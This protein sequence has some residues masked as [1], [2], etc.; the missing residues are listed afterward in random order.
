MYKVYEAPTEQQVRNRLQRKHRVPE[1]VWN[2]PHIKGI[3]V[4]CTKQQCEVEFEEK[5]DYLREQVNDL[6]ENAPPETAPVARL[7][8]RRSTGWRTPKEPAVARRSRAVSALVAMDA[9]RRDDV[10]A[11]RRDVLGD[12]LL[13]DDEVAEWIERQ[14]ELE[15]G[16]VNSAS[17]TV[18]IDHQTGEE[19]RKALIAA[20]RDGRR[21]LLSELEDM[22]IQDVIFEADALG[23]GKPGDNWTNWV[24][25]NPDGM[26][27]RLQ[28]LAKKLSKDYHWDSAQAVHFILTDL[29]PYCGI[30]A[31]LQYGHVT[32]VV[33]SIPPW[34]SAADVARAYENRR[35]AF[36][37]LGK[38]VLSKRPQ[39][40]SE[41]IAHLMIFVYLHPDASWRERCRLWR[42]HP[43]VPEEWHYQDGQAMSTA[44]NRAANILAK[45]M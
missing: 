41:R 15:K 31:R 6:I 33:L 38:H 25:V 40:I 4:T 10:K 11:F 3:V 22:P 44:F 13:A 43:D 17:L 42:E 9:R 35:D 36:G 26:L 16:V 32:R 28:K 8:M 2:V 21:L 23:Y 1:W 5:L 20:H 24:R 18:R 7:D 29:V 30:G 19:I 37:G 34:Y 12:K 45:S 14:S 39:S 27:G